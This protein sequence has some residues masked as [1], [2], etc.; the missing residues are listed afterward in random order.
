MSEREDRVVLKIDLSTGTIELDSPAASFNEAIEKTKELAATL[1]L[2]GKAPLVSPRT[3]PPPESAS[4]TN[5]S[6][7]PNSRARTRA[8]RSGARAGRI[9]SYEP[10]ADLLTEDQ[11]IELRAFM[12]EKAPAEQSD[13]VLVAMVKGEQLLGRKGLIYNEIYTLMWLGGVKDLPKALDVVLGN[14]IQNQFVVRDGPGF[15]VKFVGRNRVDNDLPRK[16]GG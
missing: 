15:T 8:V 10:V 14:M 5:E 3:S 2:Q 1:D 13:R 4:S 12:A 11:E 6:Q 16:N 7:Q 9:G